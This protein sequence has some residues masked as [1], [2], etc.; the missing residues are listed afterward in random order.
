MEREIDPKLPPT[1]KPKK[2]QNTYCNK[3]D[4]IW[5]YDPFGMEINNHYDYGW[6][7]TDCLHESAMDI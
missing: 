7:C 1:R 2:C 6:W 3:T 5:T 4:I